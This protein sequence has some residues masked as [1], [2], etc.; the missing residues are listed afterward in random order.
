MYMHAHIRAY[1]CTYNMECACVGRST[2]IKFGVVFYLPPPVCCEGVFA[3]AV[4]FFLPID[5]SVQNIVFPMFS[6]FSL[7]RKRLFFIC[8][9]Q[10]AVKVCLHSRSV[11]SCNLMPV[12]KTLF[13]QR[14]PRF[15]L[16][17]KISQVA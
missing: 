2:C 1:L 15:S 5:A 12:L 14:F 8:H 4:C 17:R 9:R 16:N 6:M 11:F 7:N 13:S 10:F 3:L